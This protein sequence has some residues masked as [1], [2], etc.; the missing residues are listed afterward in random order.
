MSKNFLYIFFHLFPSFSIFTSHDSSFFFSCPVV[1]FR[2]A[3]EQVQQLH[4]GSKLQIHV[5]KK[6]IFISAP[7]VKHKAGWHGLVENSNQVKLMCQ[8]AWKKTSEKHHS[9]SNIDVTPNQFKQIVAMFFHLLLRLR[10]CF[11]CLVVRRWFGTAVPRRHRSSAPS[12][13]RPASRTR[14]SSA[15]TARMWRPGQ[16]KATDFLGRNTQK[17]LRF[18]NIQT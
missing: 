6:R 15:G 12:P 1:F 16:K 2:F 8:I 10:F 13:K 11:A 9:T 4:D 14:P 18:M 7:N 17:K 5:P 3:V